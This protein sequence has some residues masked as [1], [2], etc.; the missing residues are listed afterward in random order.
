METLADALVGHRLL[1]SKTYLPRHQRRAVPRPRLLERL[2]EGMGSALTLVSAPAGFGKSTLLAAWLERRQRASVGEGSAAWLSLDAGDNEPSLYWTYVITALRT[3]APTVGTDA[4]ALLE[5]RSPTIRQVL[6]A[7]LNDVATLQR[8]VV[9]VLDDYHVI[10]SREVHDGMAFLLDH[11]PARLHLVL[12]SRADP[13]LPL[14][15]MRARGELTELRAADLRFTAAEAAAYL[16]E[17]M[18]LPLTAQDVSTLG[19][20]T[21][22][23]IAALQLAALSMQGREDLAGFVA[24]FAGDDR[25]IVDYLVEE[26][27]QRQPEHIRAF[28]LD[29]CVLSRM[30]APLCDAVTGRADGRAMLE[31]L[32]RANLFLVPLDDRRRW[33]RY[34]HLFA[35]VLQSRLLD[36][37]PVEVAELH[38]RASGWFAQHGDHDAAIHHA[39]AARD[40]PLAAHLIEAAVPAMSRARREVT[41]RAWL[42]ALP[43]ELFRDRPVLSLAFVGALLSTGEVQGVEPRLRDAER[44]VDADEPERAGRDAEPTEPIVVDAAERRRLPAAVAVY[45]SGLALAGGDAAATEHHARRALDLVEPD[46]R[47]R[48]GAASALLG[49]ALWGRGDLEGAYDGYAEASA[50][51]RTAGYISDVLGC[52]ITLADIRVTQGRLGDALSS[53]EHGL[54]LAL[55]QPAPA[56]RGIADMHVGISTIQRERGALD[57]AAEHLAQSERLGEH[58]GLPKH[59]YRW[60]EAMAQLRAAEGDPAAA[61]TLLDDADH[62]YVADMAPNLRPIPAL[63]ARAWLAQ[64]RVAEALAW[65]RELRLSVDEDLSFLREFEHVTLA[66]ILLARHRAQPGTDSLG[67]AIRLLDRLL[68]AADAGGRAGTAIEILVLQAIAHQLGGDLPAA[69]VPLQRALAL[70]EPEGYVRVFVD[71]GHPMAVLLRAAA[72]SAPNPEYVTRLLG[73]VAHGDPTPRRT[74]T[75]TTL[76]EPL[77]PREREVLGLLDTELSGPDIAR[78]LVVSLNTVRTHTKSIYA[79]LGVTSR[80]AAVLRGRETGQLGGERGRPA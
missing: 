25:Y 1:E 33:Y 21:E 76:F 70:A 4:L 12:S 48:R 59:P 67:D 74:E 73:S 23:W 57:A 65:A 71:E 32:D 44:W 39:L 7:L 2:D 41:L 69:L 58:T 22:G 17:A 16:V 55:A 61:V 13:P 50:S 36:E 72:R 63:R 68:D 29:T 14:A 34:H 75:A 79:K 53:Y 20:R 45:R 15:R 62:V 49:L 9:L 66:R 31:A 6:T 42:E 28:L 56:P 60:R 37:R 38:R 30:T 40:H 51:F 78:R 26:V 5:A 43:E 46:D 18:H 54:Q 11:A 77:S 3:V 8:D 24:A 27:L 52:A 10:E 80:R 35:E 47:F 64:G 19:T